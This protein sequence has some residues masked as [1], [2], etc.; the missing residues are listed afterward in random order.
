MLAQAARLLADA[1]LQKR[2]GEA[3]LAFADRHR[4]ATRRTMD[5]IAAYLK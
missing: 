5:L 1:G 4:G 2:M 3:G